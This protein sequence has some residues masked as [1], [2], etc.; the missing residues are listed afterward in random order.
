[1]LNSVA[2]ELSHGSQMAFKK[3]NIHR[4][5]VGDLIT[6]GQLRWQ[7]KEIRLVHDQELIGALVFAYNK[8]ALDAVADPTGGILTRAGWELFRP[9]ADQN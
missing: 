9:K 1:M 8:D 2:L 6:D 5:M 3:V 7:V 4:P